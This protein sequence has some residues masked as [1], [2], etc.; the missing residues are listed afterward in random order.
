MYVDCIDSLDLVVCN[1]AVTPGVENPLHAGCVGAEVDEPLRAHGGVPP[2]TFTMT[3]GELLHGLTFDSERG[4]LVGK[5]M[6]QDVTPLTGLRDDMQRLARKQWAHR[7]K[8]LDV[9]KGSGWR[10][11]TPD[12]AR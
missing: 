9:K 2:Y 5:S 10:R 8:S 7:A 1:D 3:G 11:S 12:E 4:H 6:G